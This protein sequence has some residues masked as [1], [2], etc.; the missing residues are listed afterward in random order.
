MGFK[1]ALLLTLLIAPGASLAADGDSTSATYSAHAGSE[2]PRHVYWGD[3]HLHSLLSVDANTNGNTQLSGD[4]AFR[5]A[6]GEEIT[7]HNAMRVR[8]RRP[9]DFL[10][11]SDHAEYLGVIDGIA[12]GDA[13][14][15][16]NEGAR[17]WGRMLAAGDMTPM[18]EF[19][20]SANSGVAVFEHPDFLRS[21]WRQV[22]ETANRNNRA[23]VFTAFI[24]Y[25]WT[26]MPGGKNL[27]R[28]VLFKDGAEQTSQILP[29]S[30]L[31][32][33]DP[34]DLWRFLADYESKTGGDVFCNSA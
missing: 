33:A 15:L 27:H 31:D 24:G 12:R 5:F 9:L 2:I 20:A 17:R 8:L 13:L 18:R 32:S 4:D 16:E 28:V 6:R 25:E 14:L 19:A 22:I 34:E 3:T 23:G 26:S 30:A 7:A 1:I 11:V 21:V 29:F 10:V